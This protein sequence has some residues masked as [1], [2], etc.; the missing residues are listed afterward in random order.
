MRAPFWFVVLFD[1]PSKIIS[2]ADIQRTIGAFEDINKV[3]HVVVSLV[4]K[5]LGKLNFVISLRSNKIGCCGTRTRTWIL[6]F[7]AACPT[8]RRSRNNIKNFTSIF[9]V[10]QAGR[11]FFLTSLSPLWFTH[12]PSLT[13]S[14]RLR[15]PV[16]NR[17]KERKWPG[18]KVFSLS[19]KSLS[20]SFQADI[21]KK[22]A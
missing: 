5:L 7:R 13:P 11:G 20:L 1:A 19:T 6:R 2:W 16:D 15:Y 22:S 21:I 18:I 17:P 10:F 4:V 9:G 14:L 12:N 8:I 3:R